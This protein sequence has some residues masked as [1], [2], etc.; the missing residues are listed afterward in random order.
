MC[1]FHQLLQTLSPT[2][3]SGA[4]NESDSLTTNDILL[5]HP[6]GYF[7]QG[8]TPREWREV[9]VMGSIRKTRL[10]RR[11]TYIQADP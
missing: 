8:A 10:K 2:W 1:N 3:S 6:S 11:L 7:E 4:N 5:M 9:T